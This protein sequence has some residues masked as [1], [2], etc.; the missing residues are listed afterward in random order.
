LYFI[1]FSKY[2]YNHQIKEDDRAG[3]VSHIGEKKNVYQDL[4]EKPEGK[5]TLKT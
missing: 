1:L 4:V 5:R 3:N 2:Y